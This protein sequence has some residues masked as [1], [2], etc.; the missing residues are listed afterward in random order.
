M[1]TVASSGASCALPGAVFGR[2][3]YALLRAA[4]ARIKGENYDAEWEY[5]PL[6][7]ATNKD[8]VCGPL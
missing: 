5:T 1:G 4:S 7:V 6:E 3:M 2:T 8:C